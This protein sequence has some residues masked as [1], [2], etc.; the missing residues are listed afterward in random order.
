MQAH[1]LGDGDVVPAAAGARTPVG[2]RAR[3]A[4]GGM[5][6]RISA[7]ELAEAES[8][9]ACRRAVTC[10]RPAA[11]R[12]TH[13]GSARHEVAKT[14]ATRARMRATARRAGP[15]D[16]L[17]IH[18]KREDGV[19]GALLGAAVAVG[20]DGSAVVHASFVH[21]SVAGNAVPFGR[22]CKQKPTK[23]AVNVRRMRYWVAVNKTSYAAASGDVKAQRQRRGQCVGIWGWGKPDTSTT[24]PAK[25]TLAHRR[26]CTNRR[27]RARLPLGSR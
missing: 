13:L 16:I 9:A 15:P 1:A 20:R 8:A 22:H 7:H 14:G 25:H 17:S 21:A 4:E 26:R 23:H 27:G 11:M 24:R 18:V 5:Y 2:A 19:L 10:V 12:G 3:A 6:A